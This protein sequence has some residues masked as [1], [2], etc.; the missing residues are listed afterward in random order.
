MTTEIKP[1]TY[2]DL[3]AE[4]KDREKYLAPGPL[5]MMGVEYDNR[6]QAIC[7]PAANEDGCIVS[8]S[9]SDVMMDAKEVAYWRLVY[10]VY[11]TALDRGEDPD[12]ADI[13]G[14]MS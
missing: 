1:V 7:P 4:I 5:S 3:A 6:M 11:E 13:L 12:V 8:Y 10:W 2:A 9:E 14:Q